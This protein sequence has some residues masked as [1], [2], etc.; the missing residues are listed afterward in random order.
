MLFTSLAAYDVNISETQTADS[1][2][3]WAIAASVTS[4]CLE[5]LQTS[6]Q[7]CYISSRSQLL[8]CARCWDCCWSSA[9]FGRSRARSHART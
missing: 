1:R 5:A 9:V 2:R 6:I 4:F 8:L 7:V 3:Q